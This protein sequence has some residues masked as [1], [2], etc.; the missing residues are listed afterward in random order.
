[1]YLFLETF[2]LNA[3]GDTYA[4]R[5]NIVLAAKTRVQRSKYKYI[6]SIDGWMARGKNA[7]H[8]RLVATSKHVSPFACRVST[9][10][11]ITKQGRVVP[12]TNKTSGSEAV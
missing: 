2:V 5:A 9:S 12:R 1:M 10:C 4:E 8:E 3:L 6:T 11:S 7:V